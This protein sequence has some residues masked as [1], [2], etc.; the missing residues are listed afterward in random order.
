MC[1]L[2][3][4]ISQDL[5]IYMILVNQRYWRIWILDLYWSIQYRGTT[6][7]ATFRRYRYCTGR[8]RTYSNRIGRFDTY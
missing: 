4:V 1:A 3:N 6:S 2:R 8:S 7:T 5:N